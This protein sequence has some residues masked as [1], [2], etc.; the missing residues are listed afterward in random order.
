MDFHVKETFPEVNGEN[1]CEIGHI[2]TY[3]V[4]HGIIERLD[5]YYGVDFSFQELNFGQD[6]FEYFPEDELIEEVQEGANNEAPM[7]AADG[8]R[9]LPED[10]VEDYPSAPSTKAKPT[11]K[12][13]T[14]VDKNAITVNLILQQKK[15][16]R[17]KPIVKKPPSRLREVQNA[18]DLES[19]EPSSPVNRES[20]PATTVDPSSPFEGSMQSSRPVTPTSRRSLGRDPFQNYSPPNRTPSTQ[21]FI[22]CRSSSTASSNITSKD[23]FNI[24]ANLRFYD[25]S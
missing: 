25:K 14:K 11:N 20:S 3:A 1:F 9:T 17:P 13:S 15:T 4:L 18:E 7:D 2:P 21:C 10:V 24:S 22:S 12:K 5:H 19:E 8:E 6:L 16:R 23:F